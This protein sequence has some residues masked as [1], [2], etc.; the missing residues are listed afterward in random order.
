M[1]VLT[2]IAIAGVAAAG[3]GAYTSNRN[4]SA[5]ARA[6]QAIT[7]KELEQEK[8]RQ[9]AMELDAN[10]RG[11]EN[12][13]GMQRARSL[14]LASS[15]NQGAQFSSGLQG[16]YGQISGQGR[17]VAVGI[18]QNLQFGAQMFDLNAQIA[19]QKMALA[20]YQSGIAT[21]SAISSFGSSMLGS[22]GPL[23]R[24]S[25]G[26]G[27]PGGSAVNGGMPNSAMTSGY[28]MY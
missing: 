8:V 7:Q 23:N 4:A 16:G 28:G 3:V 14:A 13:R 5:A 21:G 15:T 17:D 12:I 26:F 6:Q 22:L 18:S 2:A 27:S 24:L 20:K 11:L 10:R 25:Q 9:Q 1:A 19:Q